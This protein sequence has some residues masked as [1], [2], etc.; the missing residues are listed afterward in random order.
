[1]TWISGWKICSHEFNS[2]SCTRTVSFSG[3]APQIRKK[4]CL[5]IYALQRFPLVRKIISFNRPV[6]AD[7]SHTMFGGPS[8]TVRRQCSRSSLKTANCKSSGNIRVA[9]RGIRRLVAVDFVVD[10]SESIRDAA[11]FHT[12]G[13]FSIS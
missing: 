11:W 4:Q 9:F 7:E 13:S 2:A 3:T 8:T 5:R 10:S 1:M 6:A 12:R